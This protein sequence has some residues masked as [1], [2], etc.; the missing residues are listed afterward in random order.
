MD[1]EVLST[2]AG[3]GG[4]RKPCNRRDRERFSQLTASQR[5]AVATH[6]ATLYNGTRT[7]TRCWTEALD[8]A[9][10]PTAAD[11]LAEIRRELDEGHC[12]CCKHN[13][14]HMARVYALLGLEFPTTFNDD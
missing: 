6:A 3:P 5:D 12:H 4:W 1:A 2:V 13:R 14:G 8:E 7:I 9:P 10:E 11:V